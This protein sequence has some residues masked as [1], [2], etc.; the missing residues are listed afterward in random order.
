[1]KLSR[2]QLRT[3]IESVISEEVDPEIGTVLS[4]ARDLEFYISEIYKDMESSESG[5]EV[6]QRTIIALDHLQK[7]VD[8]MIRRY[9][10]RVKDATADEERRG[11]QKGHFLGSRWVPE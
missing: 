2:K 4:E 8:N 3:L 7:I 10:L 11:Q 5:A 1:M 6:G 9:S